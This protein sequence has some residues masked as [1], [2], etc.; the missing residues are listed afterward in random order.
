MTNLGNEAASGNLD[1][2]LEA[3]GMNEGSSVVG[4]SMEVEYAPP[5]NPPPPSPPVPRPPV[6]S[7][8][9]IPLPPR[10]P[11]PPS[12]P[13]PP[14]PPPLVTAYDRLADTYTDD[15]K[16]WKSVYLTTGVGLGFLISGCITG[17]AIATGDRHPLA[18]G[19]FTTLLLLAGGF[20]AWQ[21]YE[22][23]LWIAEGTEA[24]KA[25]LIVLIFAGCGAAAVAIFGRMLFEVFRQR[26]YGSHIP[27]L[28]PGMM[29]MG[30]FG[31][32]PYGSWADP[33]FNPA[34]NMYG[35]PRM[36][37][38]PHRT[39]I[40]HLHLIPSPHFPHFCGEEIFVSSSCIVI[41]GTEARPRT[42]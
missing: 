31:S 24:Y 11:R 40:A 10:V 4:L 2:S 19:V 3:E 37:T 5:P 6:P 28:P 34:Y 8:P 33:G 42:D 22:Q 21:C 41:S 35:D 36:V 27:P 18:L 1:A 26:K 16:T 15:W 39:L 30:S 9:P 23:E 12:Q 20:L 29:P 13:S 38:T 32:Q 7:P 14:P 17:R 25:G